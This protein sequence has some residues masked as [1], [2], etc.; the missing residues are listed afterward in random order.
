VRIG[1]PEAPLLQRYDEHVGGVRHRN[2]ERPHSRLVHDE[3]IE[4]R[5]ELL[6]R[7]FVHWQSV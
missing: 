7:D 6:P 4:F 5:D 2:E 1:E 3:M